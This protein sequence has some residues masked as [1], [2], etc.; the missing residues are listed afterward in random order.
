MG[1]S[2]FSKAPSRVTVS[3]FLAVPIKGLG[4]WNDD[5]RSP[6]EPAIGQGTEFP[7]RYFTL[8]SLKSNTS[9]GSSIFRKM[10]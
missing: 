2:R 6:A 1:L 9:T 4:E 3:R 7:M 8:A 10:T 5:R